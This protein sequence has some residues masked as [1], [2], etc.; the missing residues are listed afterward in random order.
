MKIALIILNYRTA[1]LTVDCLRSLATEVDAETE[2]VVV[3][4]ASG[5]GSADRI[6]DA[7]AEAGWGAWARVLRSP[8]NGGFAAGNNYGMAAVTA[9]AYLLSNS[10]V[11]FE[12]GS[13]AALRAAAEARPEAGIIGPAMV[14]GDGGPNPS[15]FRLLTPVTEF[16]R[17]ASLGPLTRLL[18]GHVPV[19]EDR[20]GPFEPGWLGFACVLI[21]RDVVEAIGGLDETFFMYFEDV[22]YCRRARD[23]GFP[24]LYWPAARV[25]HL[26]GGTSGV[27]TEGAR[28]DR[29]P[30]YFYASRTHYFRKHYGQLGLLG[31]NLLFT[32]G[33]GL[34]W[35][36]R[37]TGRPMPHRAFE[38]LDIWRGFL[39]PR[40]SARIPTFARSDDRRSDRRPLHPAE[41]S[42]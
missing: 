10:D 12:E 39:G 20:E 23:A 35:L 27:T 13:L 28:A 8:D 5:D 41:V 6:E 18:R 38:A 29:A 7:I 31:T 15:A 2:V 42:R 21:R 34:A 37:A 32:T 36:R 22:D 14:T 24:L 26:L 9:D 40:E 33:Y 17:A 3:D 16:L 19:I 30:P 1:E 11:I 4:N 25:V